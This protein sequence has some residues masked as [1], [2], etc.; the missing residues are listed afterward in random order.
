MVVDATGKQTILKWEV[1]LNGIMGSSKVSHR[2]LTTVKIADIFKRW[3]LVQSKKRVPGWELGSM[4]FSP[5]LANFTGDLWK[6]AFSEPY[7]SS[8]KWL[9]QWLP[10][11]L[12]PVFH[13]DSIPLK[14]AMFFLQ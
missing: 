4:N 11:P 9:Y 10:K 6:I 13:Y 2:K 5:H 7:S 8:L 1:C 14:E 12:S 3:N